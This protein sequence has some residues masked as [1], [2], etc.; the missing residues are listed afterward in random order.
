ML[1]FTVFMFMALKGL[2]FMSPLYEDPSCMNGYVV[3]TDNTFPVLVYSRLSCCESIL[4]IIFSD[5]IYR[6]ILNLFYEL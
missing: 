1:S 4:S 3:L 5:S 2:G 6:Y